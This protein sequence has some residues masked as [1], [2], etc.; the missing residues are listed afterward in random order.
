M[1]PLPFHSLK[2]TCVDI[3]RVKHVTLDVAAEFLATQPKTLVK[4]YG[5]DWDSAGQ[6]LVA[7]ALDDLGEW[8]DWSE[9][10]EAVEALFAPDQEGAA[11]SR[12][13]RATPGGPRGGLA[14]WRGFRF[15]PRRDIRP[16]HTMPA[17]IAG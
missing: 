3:L 5:D 1:R 12:H 11:R 4:Y 10:T 17:P 2:H 13:A 9:E 16:G 14:P 15:R 6:T 8:E 7:A